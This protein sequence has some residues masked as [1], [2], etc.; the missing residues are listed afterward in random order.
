MSKI[1]KSGLTVDEV[2]D[3]VIANSRIEGLELDAETI[4]VVRQV[5]GGEMTR[6]EAAEWR[7]ARAAQA[8][9]RERVKGFG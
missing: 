4:E 7:R 5:A 9:A 3:Q 2:V 8:V 6:E 1:T